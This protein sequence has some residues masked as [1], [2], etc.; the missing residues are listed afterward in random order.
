MN[1]QA[2]QSWEVLHR[3]TV[4]GEMLSAS[5]QAVYDAGCRELDMEEN[6]YGNL[7]QVRALR[8]QIVDASA[9]QHR[10]LTRKVELNARIAA[11]EARLDTRTGRLLSIGS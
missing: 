4:S 9:E 3:R 1:E 10:L 5:E 11:L 6:L 8:A 7:E 2:Y